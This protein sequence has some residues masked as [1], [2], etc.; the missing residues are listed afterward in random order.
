[1]SKHKKFLVFEFATTTN[2]D[3]LKVDSILRSL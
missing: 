1:M 3:I 2:K